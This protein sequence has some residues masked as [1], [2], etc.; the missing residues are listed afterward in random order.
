MLG[1]ALG[2]AGSLQAALAPRLLLAPSLAQ[3]MQEL[4]LGRPPLRH[5]HHLKGRAEHPVTAGRAENPVIACLGMGALARE[6]RAPRYRPPRNGGS[7]RL[8]G[9]LKGC[10]FFPP[11]RCHPKRGLLGGGCGICGIL[12]ASSFCAMHRSMGKSCGVFLEPS[13]VVAPFCIFLRR[14]KYAPFQTLQ[15]IFIFLL[16]HILGNQLNLCNVNYKCC[17]LM[18]SPVF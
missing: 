1:S 13:Y 3:H 9:Q 6:S 17:F 5:G 8:M 18:V 10:L 14:L 7:V 16:H 4:A 12:L 2:G 15:L 11:L